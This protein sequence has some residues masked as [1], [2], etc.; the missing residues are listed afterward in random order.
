MSAIQVLG[1]CRFSYPS[2]PGG[3]EDHAMDMDAVRAKLY[4]PSRLEL[5]FLWFEHVALPS[6]RRQTDPD[7]TLVVLAGDHLPAPYRAR[8]EALLADVPQAKL[9]IMPEGEQHRFACRRAMLAHRN[10][11][12]KAVAEFRLDDD[13]AVAEIFVER[14][15]LVFRHVRQLFDMRPRVTVDFCRGVVLRATGD[16]VVLRPVIAQHWTPALIT[17]RA[18]DDQMS[19]LDALHTRLWKGMPQLT[20][21]FPPMYVRGSHEVNES[22]IDRRW[23]RIETWKAEPDDLRTLLAESFGIDLPGM[24]TALDT[25]LRKR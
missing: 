9:E 13:D 2:A 12:A 1:L 6:M 14:A 24:E 20:M 16:G 8:L 21:P 10:P 25:L 23:D 11:D 5:R 3:F 18:P 22:E 15:R 7:F 4:E 17:Y 19:L